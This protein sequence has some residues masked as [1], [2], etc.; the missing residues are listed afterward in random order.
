MKVYV[1]FKIASFECTVEGKQYKPVRA[2]IGEINDGKCTSIKLVKCA[3]DF[4]PPLEKRINIFFDENG[5][6]V[7]H[8]SAE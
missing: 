3:S 5:K 6:A 1:V 7:S 8:K 2:M 4:A